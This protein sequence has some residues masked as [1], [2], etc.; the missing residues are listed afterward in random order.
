MTLRIRPILRLLPTLVAV[1][2]AVL[3]LRHLWDYYTAAPWTR[4]GHVRADIVQI[5]PDVSGLVTRVLVRDNQQVR[6]GEVLFEIDRDRYALALQQATANAAA[7]RATLA[8][9]RREAARNRSLDGLVAGEVAE[10]GRARV[11]QAEAALAQAEAS[12]RLARLNL[13]RT[14]VL[15]P[16]DG[17]LNDRL[18][19]LGDYVSTGRPVL[20]MIDAAS[21]HVEGYFEETKL[22]RIRIGSPV[23]VH[24]MGEPRHLRGHVQSIAAGIEDRDRGAGSNL[25]PNVNPT[26]NWVRLAQR[27]PVRITLE[28]VPADVRLVSGRTATVSVQQ[29]SMEHRP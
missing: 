20:S 8:Q 29:P 6:R 4:D 28:A 1:V 25:L 22:H 11:E 17:Y 21:F 23:D 27:V 3:V 14:S 19:R 7:L 12:V 16:A 18:P 26:F 24:I 10:Q 15:S 2:A 9:A 13:E 5:A